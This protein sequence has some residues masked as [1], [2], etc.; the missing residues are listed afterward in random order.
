MKKILSVMFEENTKILKEEE[1]NGVKEKAKIMRP[2]EY[3]DMNTYDPTSINWNDKDS[4][5]QV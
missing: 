5:V 4:C 2:L 1:D 3:I